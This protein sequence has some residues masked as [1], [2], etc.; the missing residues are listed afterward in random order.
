MIDNKT[1][2][3]ETR[4]RLLA[5]VKARAEKAAAELESR[6]LDKSGKPASGMV[7]TEATEYED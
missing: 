4:H 1:T 5:E 3:E 2:D 6:R 7:D